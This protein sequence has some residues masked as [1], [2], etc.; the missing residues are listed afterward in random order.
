M[1]QEFTA[2]VTDFQIVNT[3]NPIPELSLNVLSS[4]FPVFRFLILVRKFARV[5]WGPATQGR[6]LPA[7]PL[8]C[9]DSSRGE[10]LL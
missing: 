1:T 6:V 7:C 5:V 9:E 3:T 8:L 4:L 2:D 10:L